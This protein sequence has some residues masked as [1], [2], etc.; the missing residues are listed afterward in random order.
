MSYQPRLFF[1]WII[2]LGHPANLSEVRPPLDIIAV[3]MPSNTTS[4]FQQMD[5]GVIATIKAY[6][7]HQTMS[8]GQVRQNY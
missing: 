7:L 5:K 2:P 8:F 1:S 6:Y 4:L 3:Y